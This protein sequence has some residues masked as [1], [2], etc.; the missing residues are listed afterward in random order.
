MSFYNQSVNEMIALVQCY[1][2]IC[3]GKEV[4]IKINNHRDIFLLKD[5]Y[6]IA[7]GWM[8]LNCK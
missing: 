7:Q 4:N 2:H 6:Q 3:T 1:I 8:Q 5:A